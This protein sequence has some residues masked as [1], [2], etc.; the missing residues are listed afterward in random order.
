[1]TVV[2]AAAH[3]SARESLR[4]RVWTSVLAWAVRADNARTD[5]AVIGVF[6]L[7]VGLTLALVPELSSSRMLDVVMDT[8][9][10]PVWATWF[11]LSAVLVWAGLGV[12]D[13]HTGGRLRH[14]AWMSVG[15]LGVM[16]LAGMIW[17]LPVG[18]NLIG[19]L[20]SAAIQSWY[21]LTVVRLELPL[22]AERLARRTG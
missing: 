21:S 8:L 3:A 14:L 15:T 20:F 22:L 4:S 12:T 9:P 11:L 2:H 7:T 6:N 13:E 16:W 1:M 10:R 19:V 5:F 17:A 18:G